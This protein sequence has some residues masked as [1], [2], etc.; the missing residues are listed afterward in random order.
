MLSPH[1]LVRRFGCPLALLLSA[2]WLWAGDIDFT[3]SSPLLAQPEAQRTQSI[4]ARLAA[5]PLAWPGG[6]LTAAE[7]I[8]L[9]AAS[10]NPTILVD[11]A[12]AMRSAELPALAGDYWQGVVA[13][14]AAFDLT[15]EP[16][17]GLDQAEDSGRYGN[18]DNSGTALV[19]TGGPLL[20]RGRDATAARPLYVPCG[21]V[22]AEI[23]AFDLH[24]RQGAIASRTADVRLALR[25][26]PR[27]QPLQIG[28]TLVNWTTVEDPLG[29][30]LNSSEAVGGRRA[31]VSAVHLSDVQESFTGCTLTGELLVQ[32][33]EPVT[34][35]ATIRPGEKARAD[36]LGQEVSMQFIGE[37]ETTANG[38]RGP[39]F[40]LSV[41]TAVLGTRPKLTVT[42][43]GQPLK[44]NNQG[45][46]WSGGRIELFYR[47]PKLLDGAYGVTLTGQAAL[48]QVRMPLRVPIAVARLPADERPLTS[49]L[50]LQVP[51]QLRWDAGECDVAEA[52]RRLGGANQVLLE[53]GADERRR[54]M[55]PVFDGSFWEGVLVVCRAF[56]LT[57]LPPSQA[58]Q[59]LNQEGESTP[60]CITGGPLCLG[61]RNGDRPGVGNFQA[62]GILLMVMDA[63]TVVTNQG[64]DGV[65]RQ[66]EVSY[67]LRLEPRLDASLIG[68]ATVSWTSLAGVGDGR[69]LVVEESSIETTEED[70]AQVQMRVMRVGRRLVRVAS[71]EAPA[72]ATATGRVVVSGLPSGQVP[73]TL[74]GQV[75]LHLR[76]PV[77][78]ELSL[79][80]GGRSIARLGD[81]A[82][83]VKMFSAAGEEDGNTERSGVSVE[84]AG[85]QIDALAVEVRDAAGKSVRSNGSGNSG[86]NGRSRLLW[87][88]AAF[89]QGPYTVVLTARERLGVL[90]LPFNLSAVTP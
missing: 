78:A 84:M 38:Q 29:R 42:L 68:S 65:T 27:V 64:L 36:L 32:T 53:L 83:M 21:A 82:A 19:A 43:G 33:L 54:A 81:R 16:G 85:D 4:Q 89:D 45:S 8:A 11:P 34:L 12:D 77:R 28:T 26:E 79:A 63:L 57:I 9:L 14:C 88:F 55:L 44:F 90:R 75:A 3:V 30:K 37:G 10:G 20:L 17:E 24:Q 80:P 41:P 61:P 59:G 18:R 31:D 50:D 74:S 62:S 69:P 22:L 58:V 13:V 23:L 48:Q 67:R 40:S 70:D 56:D 1:F 71:N 47:G 51:S 86:S 76:R 2:A 60:T 7:A 52:V 39:G 15:L 87:Y 35:G 25:L 6:R 66:A 73:L 49:G 5:T 72:G 46:H